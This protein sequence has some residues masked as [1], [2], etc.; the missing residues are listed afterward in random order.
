MI[1]PFCNEKTDDD[2]KALCIHALQKFCRKWAELMAKGSN[3]MLSAGI[4]YAI[5][6]NCSLDSSTD[7]LMDRPKYPLIA[8]EVNS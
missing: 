6:K 7:I 5:A 1:I 3:N 4:V 2:Y 8:D